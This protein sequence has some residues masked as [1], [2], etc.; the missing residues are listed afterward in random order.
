MLLIYRNFVFIKSLIEYDEL[1]M[2]Y[3][4]FDVLVINRLVCLDG[5]S[6]YA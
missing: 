1:L 4:S 2:W 5:L 6:S 3:L